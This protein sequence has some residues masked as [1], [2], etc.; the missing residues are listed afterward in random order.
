MSD[1]R[2][3]EPIA[4][5]FKSASFLALLA[6][7]GCASPGAPILRANSSDGHGPLIPDCLN[8]SPTTPARPFQTGF[9]MSTWSSSWIEGVQSG[10]NSGLRPEPEEKS[11]VRFAK[12]L[13]HTVIMR[14]LGFDGSNSPYKPFC[15]TYRRPLQRVLE[16]LR[17]MLPGLGYSVALAP[18]NEYG[19]ITEFVDREHPAARWRDRYIVT[20]LDTL[21]GETSVSIYRDLWISRQSETHVRAESNGGNE[22][23]ILQEMRRRVR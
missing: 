7:C 10:L 19:F 22:A 1:W 9:Y 16:S 3:K 11:R 17:Q 18:S 20:F 21:D 2:P 5:T 14:T 8:V 15:M 6:L 12:N 23:W 4:S 13:S